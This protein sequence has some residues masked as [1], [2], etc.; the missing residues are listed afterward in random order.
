MDP[1]SRVL[2]IPV[3]VAALLA[4]V[5]TAASAQPQHPSMHDAESAA[6]VIAES[7]NPLSNLE[8]INFNEYYA[9]ALYDSDGIQNVLNAQYVLIPVRRHYRLHH[10]I[11]AT[12]PIVTAPDGPTAYASGLGDFTLQD[13]FKFSKENAT[14]EW[15]VGPL[16]VM[17][18]ATS[19][20]LGA[21]K[22]QAGV[23][24]VVV[25]LLSGGS[26][27]G[28]AV[29]W[30]TDFAGDSSRPGTNFAT[31]Q[32]MIALAIGA[33]GF[34]ISSSP[35]CTFDFEN[36]RYLVPFSLGF[37]KVFMVG[38]TIV[39]VT[40]EPQITVYHKGEQQPAFQAFLGL[41]LQRKRMPKSAP[42]SARLQ[43]DALAPPAPWPPAA[44]SGRR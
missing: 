35:I 10:L 40:A 13:A 11:R 26:V 44:T 15:G 42:G 29:T 36:Q 7:N 9:P 21:G 24:G 43:A 39:N 32:P 27:T 31:V 2:R 25:R 34:Y 1:F 16:I 22:W 38:R 23:A 28:A 3:I 33:S 8:G 20:A 37:G 18:T 41:T 5:A 30:Q 12:L 6:R 19:D 4:V 17:P 14:T